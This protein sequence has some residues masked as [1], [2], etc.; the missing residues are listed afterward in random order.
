MTYPTPITSPLQNSV[1]KLSHLTGLKTSHLSAA[2][3]KLSNREATVPRRSRL[4]EPGETG[5]FFVEKG[6]GFS[7]SLLAAGKRHIHR[8]FA[9]GDCIGFSEGWTSGQ[10]HAVEALTEMTIRHVRM[11]ILNSVLYASPTLLRALLIEA[12]VE[13]RANDQR[14]SLIAKA[15][16][17]SRLAYHL[18][19]RLDRL[20]LTSRYH[21]GRISNAK[22]FKI[23]GTHGVIADELGMSS[24]HVSRIMS[25][26]EETELV[27]RPARRLYSL[28]DVKRLQEMCHYENPYEMTEPDAAS[29]R[30]SSS[31]SGHTANDRRFP[32]AVE[33]FA[34]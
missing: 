11:G 14:A 33:Q 19:A 18:L 5:I 3:Q 28:L 12:S 29:A 25:R 7:Y 32:M 34:E 24:V 20:R 26:L 4:V 6:H 17:Q 23:H 30:L 8:R 13:Q 10:P 9:P 15:D 16:P 1:I 2:L 31:S 21:N 27:H 22:V